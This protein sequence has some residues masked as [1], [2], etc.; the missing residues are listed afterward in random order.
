MIDARARVRWLAENGK[1]RSGIVIAVIPPGEIPKLPPGIAKHRGKFTLS[2]SGEIR[3]LVLV[4]EGTHGDLYYAPHATSCTEI[5]KRVR[6]MAKPSG[7]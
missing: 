1:W 3:V 6:K 7:Y 5:V 4:D 2:A